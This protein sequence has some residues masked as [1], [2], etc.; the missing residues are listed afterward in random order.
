MNGKY[1]D[2][3][4]S[5]KGLKRKNVADKLGIAQTTL[6]KKI[7][8]SRNTEYYW[9]CAIHKAT[10]R[11]ILHGPHNTEDEARQWGYTYVRD[12]EF[13]VYPFPTI[14]KTA[15]RDFYK[16][17]MVEKSKNISSAFTRAIYP[18]S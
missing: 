10:L 15:A 4:L 8:R 14:N 6:N 5:I 9:V 1:F 3:L 16:S 18:K 12:G 11:P 17:I 13:E 7:R 2:Y